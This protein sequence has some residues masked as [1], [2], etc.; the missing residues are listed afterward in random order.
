MT[1]R[2]KP[3]EGYATWIE[4]CLDLLDTQLYV[5]HRTAC[6]RAELAELRAALQ[7][8]DQRIAELEERVEELV[9]ERD[10]QYAELKRLRG[11]GQ[12]E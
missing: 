6:A 12:G 2:P 7:A 5:E 3:P 10:V 9:R 8:R 11:R 4:N 1:D